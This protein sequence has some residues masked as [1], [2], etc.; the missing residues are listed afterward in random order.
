MKVE[1]QF[2]TI[3]MDFWASLEHKLRYKKELPQEKLDMLKVDLKSC[4]DDSARWDRKMQEIREYLD[5]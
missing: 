3:A 1:V 4:A 2:R 5:E